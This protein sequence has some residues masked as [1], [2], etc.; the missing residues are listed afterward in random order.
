MKLY[1]GVFADAS[2]SDVETTAW[3]IQN[4][5][6]EA[7]LEQPYQGT[8]NV[9]SAFREG[10]FTTEQA[11]TALVGYCALGAATAEKEYYAREARV[12]EELNGLL[13]TELVS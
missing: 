10:A 11:I 3:E 8:Q 5:Y 9:L 4:V 13:R 12:I 2:A 1:D 7:D 6:I